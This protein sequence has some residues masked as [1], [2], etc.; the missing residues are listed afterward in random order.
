MSE[1]FTTYLIEYFYGPEMIPVQVHIFDDGRSEI[2][3]SSEHEL[4]NSIV[5]RSSLYLDKS[6]PAHCFE[7]IG[8][9]PV[10]YSCFSDQR[11]E[12]FLRGLLLSIL[13]DYQIGLRLLQVSDS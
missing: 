12:K 8:H 2:F 11:C 9:P 4:F 5:H 7:E 10:L 3:V 13:S 6:D 1:T